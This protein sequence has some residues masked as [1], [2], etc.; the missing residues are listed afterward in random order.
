MNIGIYDNPNIRIDNQFFM[1][2]HKDRIVEQ[3]LRY[4]PEDR[5]SKYDS[6]KYKQVYAILYK[7]KSS[8]RR[9]K[10]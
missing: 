7:L 4:Y 2:K 1:P 9:M 10:N 5:K 3:I 6:M 8:N